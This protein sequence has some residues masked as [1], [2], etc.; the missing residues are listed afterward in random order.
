MRT[1]KKLF[2]CLMLALCLGTAAC[3][4]QLFRNY[5]RIIPADGATRAFASHQVNSDYRYY[6][7]GSDL[8]PNALIGLDRR[9]RLDPQALWREVEMT[10]AKM[11][12]IVHYMN[13]MAATQR[14]FPKGFEMQDDSGRPIGLWYSLPRARTFLRMQED[15]T[16]RI[17]TPDLDTYEKKAGSLIMDSER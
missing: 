4:G 14:D 2:L 12:D 15:G 9:Y 8:H 11:M 3:T 16:V 1:Q 17:G 5:G 10:P 7:S 13:A 6:I